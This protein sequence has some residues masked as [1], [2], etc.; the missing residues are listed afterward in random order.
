[1]YYTNM[2]LSIKTKV[3]STALPRRFTVANS[4]FGLDGKLKYWIR[5]RMRNFL[6]KCQEKKLHFRMSTQRIRSLTRLVPDVQASKSN[7]ILGAVP[8]TLSYHSASVIT[9]KVIFKSDR[10]DT[11]TN[12]VG[13]VLLKSSHSP[14]QPPWNDSTS[15]HHPLLLVDYGPVQLNMV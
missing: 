13:P 10:H 4:S 12:A 1:M 2:L 9:V 6:H 7:S 5:Q 15:T 11:N 3:R 14:Y 8:S